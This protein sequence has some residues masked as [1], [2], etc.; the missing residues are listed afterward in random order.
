MPS[1]QCACR[2]QARMV[3]LILFLAFGCGPALHAQNF[4][5]LPPLEP[6]DMN[7]V[8]EGGPALILYRAADTDN[9]TSSE[10]YSYRIKILNEEGREH[11]NIEIPYV[12]KLEQ[13]EDVAART[14]APDGTVTPFHDQVTDQDIVKA[15]KYK[16][17]AKIFSIPN[18][19]VGSIIEYTYRVRYKYKIPEQ[20]KYPERYI[21]EN[22]TTFPA[23]RWDIQTDMFVKHQRFT[24]TPV[25]KMHVEVFALNMPTNTV[26]AL[27]GAGGAPIRYGECS[28]VRGGGICA[29]EKATKSWMALYYAQAFYGNNGYWMAVV[30]NSSKEF[31]KYIGKSKVVEREAARLFR[32]GIQQL[33]SCRKSTRNPGNSQFRL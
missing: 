7:V 33:K 9:T 12:E 4:P 25:N 21:F 26:R 2:A 22:P 32:R 29:P 3:G 20:F 15:K 5:G 30:K 8:G 23:A 17:H 19:Q 27:F 14:I 13:V 24:F 11:A 6:N 31:E 18:V 1:K 16:V 28:S 10:T